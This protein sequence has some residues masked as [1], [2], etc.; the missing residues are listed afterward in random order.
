MST[1]KLAKITARSAADVCVKLQLDEAAQKLLTPALTPAEFLDALMAKE[2]WIDAVRFLGMALPKREGVWWALQCAKTAP[3]PT[4]QAGAALQLAEKWVLA[5]TEDHRQ[6]ANAAAEAAGLGT[7]AGLTALAVFM[8]G[9]SMAPPESAQVP[10]PEHL[11]GTMVGNAVIMAALL[12]KPAEADGKFRQFLALGVEVAQG[13][14]RWKEPPAPPA[15]AA[16]P[17]ARPAAPAR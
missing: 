14:N 15:P 5:T 10:P 8:S 7:P 12:P 11:T 17:A 2:L 9:G 13:T 6:P 3:A 16:K 4:P 1:G